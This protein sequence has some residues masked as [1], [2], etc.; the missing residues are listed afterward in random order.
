MLNSGVTNAQ[1]IACGQ[2]LKP[3]SKTGNNHGMKKL[4]DPNWHED[5]VFFNLYPYDDQKNI[6]SGDKLNRNTFLLNANNHDFFENGVITFFDI[7]VTRDMEG[8]F[9]KVF[10]QGDTIIEAGHYFD[11]TDLVYKVNKNDILSLSNSD[12]FYG[13]SI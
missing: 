9:L 2:S 5:Y 1:K 12:M 4:S 8:G 10:E 13:P 3:R 7:N 11:K 6:M